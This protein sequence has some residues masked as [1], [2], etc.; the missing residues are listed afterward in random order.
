MAG[1]S[2]LDIS[3]YASERV[4]SGKRELTPERAK[5]HRCRTRAA[6]RW[7]AAAN[8]AK[9]DMIQIGWLCFAAGLLFGVV[10]MM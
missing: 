9:W 7:Q 5:A 4:F 10:V 3:G 1:D 2:D 6:Q 8:R